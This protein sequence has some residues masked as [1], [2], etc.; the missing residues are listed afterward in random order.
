LHLVI[1]LAFLGGYSVY[2]GQASYER[3]LSPSWYTWSWITR[4]GFINLAGFVARTK[5]YAV[6]SM[7]EVSTNVK[8]HSEFRALAS[9]PV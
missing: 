1:G 8:S 9:L 3:I 5:Y 2:G 6:W 4:L 7:S